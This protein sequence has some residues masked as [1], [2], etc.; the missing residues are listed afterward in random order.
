MPDSRHPTP[1]FDFRQARA[2]FSATLRQGMRPN[3]DA[4]GKRGASPMRGMIFSMFLAGFLASGAGGRSADLRTY[5]AFIAASAC[6]LAMFIVMP[7]TVEARQ[8]TLE[9]F[10]SRPV[11]IRTVT[12][13]S[14]AALGVI[15]A[16]IQASYI[17]YP[18]F[19]GVRDF[20]C[21]MWAV[22]PIF[23]MF[24]GTGLTLATLWATALAVAAR[25]LSAARLRRFAQLLLLVVLIGPILFSV[26]SLTGDREAPLALDALP[27]ARWLPPV[28]CVDAVF[29]GTARVVWYERLGVLVLAVAAFGL[30]WRVDADER[31][32]KIAERFSAVQGERARMPVAVRALRMIH[33][34]PG[35]GRTLVSPRAY[36]V[37]ALILTVISREEVARLRMFMFN[38]MLFAAFAAAWLMPMNSSLPFIV[39]ILGFT[40]VMD[41]S[42]IIRQ[43]SQAEATWLLRLTP[44]DG[45]AVVRG[46]RWALLMRFVPLPALLFFILSIRNGSPGL[47][48]FLLAAYVCEA[49]LVIAAS[50][51]VKPALPLSS[52]VQTANTPLGG[53]INYF[54]TIAAAL[55][56]IVVMTVLTLLYGVSRW[57]VLA[58]IGLLAAA[59]LVAE[60]WAASRLTRT[61]FLERSTRSFWRRKAVWVPLATCVALVVGSVG[62][63]LYIPPFGELPPPVSGPAPLRDADNAWNDYRNALE[64]FAKLRQPDGGFD[65]KR[66]QELTA[67]ATT[68]EVTGSDGDWLRLFY[69]FKGELSSG[70]KKPGCVAPKADAQFRFFGELLEIR[71]LL[72]R[73][74]RDADRA[75]GDGGAFDG[76]L[77]AAR[78]T[79]HLEEIEVRSGIFSSNREAAVTKNWLQSDSWTKCD[80]DMAAR[81]ARELDRELALLPLPMMVMEARIANY[82]RLAEG[83][84]PVGGDRRQSWAM[85]TFPGVRGRVFGQSRLSANAALARMRPCC[86]GWIFSRCGQPTASPERGTALWWMI[87]PEAGYAEMFEM[88]GYDAGRVAARL[89]RERCDLGALV[90]W[91]A[92]AAFKARH[93]TFPADLE[94]ACREVGI[95]VPQD[96]VTGAAVRYRLDAAGPVVWFVGFDRDDDLATKPLR[97]NDFPAG[98]YGGKPVAMPD[99]DFVYRFGAAPV[100]LG[101]V[102][103]NGVNPPVMPASDEDDGDDEGP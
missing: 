34:L 97:M 11:S 82:Q 56:H 28:W 36:G 98:G 47:A 41:S 79:R 96:A 43:S 53:I 87:L 45:M 38:L 59:V 21:P 24:W 103:R 72:W 66:L 73:I 18:L 46:T 90:A 60:V 77:L 85:Q 20:G 1:A 4:N 100:H 2:V 33:R 76:Y 65:E 102:E 84:G 68:G 67:R 95:S 10:F 64:L 29:G 44:I 32:P 92:V 62:Y 93:G 8:R 101:P 13:G 50:V 69:R 3:A 39:G 9:I 15:I 12:F 94:L 48:A 57:P 88:A 54:V 19:V 42:V 17:A 37:A 86:E 7:E 55:A 89:Y 27:F 5:L 49:C 52:D 51:I 63:L 14:L 26:A 75:A 6:G 25:W 35:I 70:A 83:I 16:L 58:G 91:S 78:F 74:A 30:R 61:A 23:L 80:A 81:M 71:G 99:G 40:H 31:L 22:V